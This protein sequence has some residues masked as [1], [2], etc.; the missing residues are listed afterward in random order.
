[1]PSITDTAKAI[2]NTLKADFPDIDWVG[3]GGYA[4]SQQQLVSIEGLEATPGNGHP[5][6]IFNWTIQLRIYGKEAATELCALACYWIQTQRFHPEVHT[7][8]VTSVTPIFFSETEP[9]QTAWA[10][11]FT[12][13]GALT[14]NDDVRPRLTFGEEGPTFPLTLVGVN[15]DILWGSE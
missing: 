10:I 6:P 4:T 14:P 11:T 7:G 8:K 2:I 9:A 12:V 5:W 13:Q 1:M 3:D 15:D